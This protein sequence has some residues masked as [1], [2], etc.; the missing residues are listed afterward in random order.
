M[1]HDHNH[2]HDQH[3]HDHE[4]GE[5]TILSEVEL[6]VRALETVL[7]EKGYVDPAALDA[8]IET[9]E[10]RVGPH[11]GARVV[12]K[13]WSDPAY[14]DWLLKDATAAIASLGYVG[15]QGE[16]MVAV[17]N[18]STVHNMVVCTLCSCYPWPVLGLPP[19]WYKSAPYRS[20]A[21]IDPRGVLKDFGIELPAGKQIKVWDSTAEVR[22]LVLPERP[23]GTEGWSE[24]D[25]A[26]LV[27]RDSM[28]GTGLP[29]QPAEV[30]R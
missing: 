14:R 8:L 28:I 3:H 4:H 25:L 9:Y 10:T 5:G 13:A 23:D 18:T 2:H 21:V 19:V 29:R 1:S 22:Y 16:H 11:N 26:K 6:R 20:R 7:V 15:R 24:E 17:E 12:A 30:A 27:T